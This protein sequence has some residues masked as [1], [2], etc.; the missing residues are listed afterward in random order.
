MGPLRSRRLD[1]PVRTHFRLAASRS[2]RRVNGHAIAG[3]AVLALAADGRTKQRGPG[4]IAL[5]EVEL[6]LP[7]PA[8]GL[9]IARAALPEAARTAWLLE[10]R[11]FSPEEAFACG[12]V[13]VLADEGRAVSD[14]VDWA[15]R[16][17]AAPRDAARAIKADLR[18][19]ALRKIA[20][21][22]A[23]SRARFVDAWFGEV[24]RAKV[25]A[26]RTALLERKRS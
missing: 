17:G 24:A 22:R 2:W 21:H 3:G 14:A 5:T 10:G 8:G 9:E 19:D 11:R 18:A 6:G 16:L 20:E 13:Q 7:L 15:R 12:A 26:I 23:A 4:A 25:G 1:D